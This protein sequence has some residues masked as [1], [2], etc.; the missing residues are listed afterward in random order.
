MQEVLRML[1]ESIDEPTFSTYSHGFPPGR[2]G[3]AALAQIP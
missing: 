3:H 2:S 1:L